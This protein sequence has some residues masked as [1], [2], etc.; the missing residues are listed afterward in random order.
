M[1]AARLS[2]RIVRTTVAVLGCVFL[3]G[4]LAFLGFCAW[5]LHETSREGGGFAVFILVMACG[6]PGIVLGS[7]GAFLVH[8]AW[9][10]DDA[11]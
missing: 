2:F 6:L 9:N 8:R 4:A 7:I 1:T 10:A 11:A 3:L 5:G